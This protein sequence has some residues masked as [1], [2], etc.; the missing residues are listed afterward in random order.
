MKRHPWLRASKRSSEHGLTLVEILVVLVILG[1]V[2][3]FLVSRFMAGGDKAKANLTKLKLEQIKSGIE[4][5]RLMYNALPRDLAD[6]TRCNEKTGQ[7]CI[8]IYEPESDA[9]FDA[10]GSPFTFSLQGNGRRY[11]I[12]SLGADGVSGGQG[13][14]FDVSISGP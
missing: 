9:L 13:V 5:Y 3:G 8:P 6:L 11:T 10:W 14:D 4:Q 12:Q 1:L 7:G 2:G